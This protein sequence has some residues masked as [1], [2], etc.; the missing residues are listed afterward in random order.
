MQAAFVDIGLHKDA[1]LYAGD[2]TTN[3][4]VYA[5]A[6]LA[7]GDEEGDADVDV[8]ELEARREAAPPIE[9]MLRKGQAGL[10]QVAQEPL[11]TKGARITALIFPPRRYP[12][13]MPHGRPNRG[14]PRERH[15]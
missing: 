15:Q 2:Y 3:L 1:F 12:V 6:M 4:G 9:D 8:E 14:S 5:R 10:V 7:G 13:D 11:G